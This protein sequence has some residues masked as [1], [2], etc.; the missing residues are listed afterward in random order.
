MKRLPLLLLPICLAGCSAGSSDES[1]KSD[2]SASASESGP[3]PAREP[4][5]PTAPAGFEGYPTTQRDGSP[6]DE[7]YCLSVGNEPGNPFNNAKT[8]FM[9][10][11]SL[12]DKPSCEM[13]ESY[14]G[15][16]W[17]DGQPPDSDPT[18]T[19]AKLEGLDYVAARRHILNYGWQP[20]DGPCEGVDDGTCRR[21]PEIGNCSAT[22]L[23]FCDMHFAR[24]GRCLVIIT[25]GGRPE[26]SEP[27]GTRVEDVVFRRGPCSKDFNA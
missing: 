26:R 8:C 20:P 21:F 5:S 4:P 17:P 25:V 16:L 22:G 24:K 27:G 14:N 10:A 18:T 1:D 23:G 6:L 7:A 11:C 15:N 2:R 9:I 13:A 12:G 19:P 3:A